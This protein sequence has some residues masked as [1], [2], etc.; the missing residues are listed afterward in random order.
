MDHPMEHDVL[1]VSM[2]WAGALMAFAPL[3]F[4]AI[5]LLVWRR[6]LHS[7]DGPLGGAGAGD[8]SD[9]AGQST[10]D[11]AQARGSTTRPK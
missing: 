3:A 8:A 10:S 11:S 6:W 1:S 2:F 9:A 5:V 4:A 7:A